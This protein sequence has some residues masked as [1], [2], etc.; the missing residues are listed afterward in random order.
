MTV[1]GT[2]GG[3]LFVNGRGFGFCCGDE[4]FA[5]LDLYIDGLTFGVCA[6]N[7]F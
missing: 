6:M 2:G 3:L 1:C 5:L 4:V 7:S